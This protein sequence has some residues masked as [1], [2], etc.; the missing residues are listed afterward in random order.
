MAKKKKILLFERW[1]KIQCPHCK[2]Y[3]NMPD[4]EVPDTIKCDMCLEMF[5]ITD[6]TLKEYKRRS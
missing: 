6:Y 3:V 5:H 1:I 4:C 2:N